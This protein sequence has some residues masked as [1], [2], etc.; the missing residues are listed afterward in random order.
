MAAVTS[1][2]LLATLAGWTTP[3]FSIT[4]ED[5]TWRNGDVELH[6]TLYLPESK[7]PHPAFIFLHGSGPES[8]RGIFYHLYANKFAENGI[9]ML[10][11]D[12]R[13][14]EESTGDYRVALYEDLAQDAVEGIEMLAERDD[15]DA[16]FL[17]VIGQSEGG[18][19]GTLACTMSP[20]VSLFIMNSGP[21]V[22]PYEQG[23]Y[24]FSMRLRNKGISEPDIAEAAIFQ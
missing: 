21:A 20:H 6:G 8:R 7:G 23:I 19:T 24:S 18:W 11:Y 15:I 22:S 4:R 12:K 1:L 13:G 14:T 16:E 5:V 17:G 3:A 10:I 2:L 9:A